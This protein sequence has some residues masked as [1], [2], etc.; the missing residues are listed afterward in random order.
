MTRKTRNSFL[1]VK[2][3]QST[4]FSGHPVPLICDARR[5]HVVK[6]D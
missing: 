5:P 3:M 1:N 6:H 4:F 2:T